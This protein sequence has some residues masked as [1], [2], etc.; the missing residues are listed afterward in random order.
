MNECEPMRV[1]LGDFEMDSKTLYDRHA[2]TWQSYDTTL[3]NN[4]LCVIH[5]NPEAKAVYGET[6]L[7]KIEE[8]AIEFN[9]NLVILDNLTKICPDLLKAD[10]VSKVIDTLRRIK[11][12]TGAGF[13]V[14]GHTVK[15]MQNICI[16]ENSYYGSA[17]IGNFFTEIFYL[18]KTNMGQFFLKHAKTKQ[19]DS[20]T[21]IVPVLNRGKHPRTGL[22]FTFIALQPL[23]V[24]QLPSSIKTKKKKP[25]EFKNEIIKMY[26]AGILQTK[27]AE[28][29]GC[30]R[31]A[32]NQILEIP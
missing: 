15:S 17:H 3:L 9:P 18:D 30:T 21:D 2:Q 14:I 7:Q 32:I 29:F 27:I 12:R 13:L 22:G 8:A 10:E 16:T 24:V 26:N 5:E 28:I 19:K 23:D 11:Q 1:L 20:W 6:L 4:N 25:S 31:S